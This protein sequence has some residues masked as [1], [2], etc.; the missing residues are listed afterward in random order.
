MARYAYVEDNKIVGVY[1]FPPKSW[2]NISNFHLLTDDELETYGFVKIVKADTVY[3]PETEM[4]SFPVYSFVGDKVIEHVE[5]QPRPVVVP[6][7]DQEWQKVKTQRNQA[8]NDFEWR[9]ARHA[10]E[11]RLGTLFTDNLEEMDRYIQALAD[12]TNQEDPFNI[13]WP[14]YGE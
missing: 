2:K 1:D 3:D 6:D 8:I 12:I 9:Y 14:T 11:Q 4:I 10:R 7:I 5:I 13:V